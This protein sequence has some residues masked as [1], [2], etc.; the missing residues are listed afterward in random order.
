MISYHKGDLLESGCDVICHQV[1]LDGVM[2]GGIA[3][4][5]AQKYPEVE[6]DY[7]LECKDNNYSAETLGGTVCFSEIYGSKNK[8]VANCFSQRRDFTTDYEW[9]KSCVFW[10]QEFIGKGK[11]KVGIPK[12]YGCGIAKGDWGVVEKIWVDAFKDNQNIELQIW[13]L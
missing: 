7:T 12:N 13:E 5:I 3:Y 6:R 10:I 2:G 8:Y 4:Q 9:L 1:N 11:C